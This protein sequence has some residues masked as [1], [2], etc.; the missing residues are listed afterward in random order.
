MGLFD[1]L[2]T[3]P[4][5]LI[6]K[7]ELLSQS[8]QSESFK[9][10]AINI[11]ETLNLLKENNT[12]PSILLNTTKLKIKGKAIRDKLLNPKIIDEPSCADAQIIADFILSVTLMHGDKKYKNSVF[13]SDKL[14]IELPV[15]GLK[16]INLKEFSLFYHKKLTAEIE[17]YKVLEIENNFFKAS[18]STH[19]RNDEDSDSE[20][21]NSCTEDENSSYSESADSLSSSYDNENDEPVETYYYKSSKSKFRFDKKWNSFKKM[22]SEE[23][24]GKLFSE[25]FS[26]FLPKNQTIEQLI[27]KLMVV[28]DDYQSSK[29]IKSKKFFSR[30]SSKTVDS[31]LILSPV[32]ANPTQATA[33]QP[34]QNFES[35]LFST[36]EEAEQLKR[37]FEKKILKTAEDCSNNQ[38][39]LENIK[40]QDKTSFSENPKVDLGKASNNGIFAQPKSRKK[41]NVQDLSHSS[42]ESFSASHEDSNK[43]WEMPNWLVC[44]LIGSIVGII[45]LAVYGLYLLIADCCS[46]T[47]T[48][49]NNLVNAR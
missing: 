1:K 21:T 13:K 26:S 43:S 19:E 2:Y 9:Q 24:W 48:V 32:E 31:A 3:I 5:E 12:A 33:K 49:D 8:C 17:Q 27:P 41:L 35:L 23:T 18:T 11:N 34:E 44:L 22:H 14:T 45:P 36:T 38:Q 28:K 37:Q 30:S 7:S 25:A 20:V 16:T 42:D 6:K 15:I 46:S 29:K 4:P 39:L 47:S 40:D 10:L